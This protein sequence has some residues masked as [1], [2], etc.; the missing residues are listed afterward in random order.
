MMT[1]SDDRF[2]LVSRR[3][4]EGEVAPGLI[5]RERPFGAADSGWRVFAGDEEGAYLA[6]PE[7]TVM[8][9]LAVLL[10]RHAEI[11]RMLAAPAGSAFE[12]RGDGFWSDV[13]QEGKAAWEQQKEPGL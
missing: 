1:V 3:V 4:H 2:C 8:V 7:N 10:E 5:Y 12:R 13:S 6:D 9:S 11:S